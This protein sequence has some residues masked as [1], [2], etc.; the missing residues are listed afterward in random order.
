[1]A[2]FYTEVALIGIVYT[3]EDECPF[4]LPLPSCRKASYSQKPQFVLSVC[5]HSLV[6]IW[7]ATSRVIH[8]RS[9]LPL[10]KDVLGL[11]I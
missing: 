6:A 9:K 7:R 2:A 11:G 8:R 10:K 1:M 4:A 3:T 5:M